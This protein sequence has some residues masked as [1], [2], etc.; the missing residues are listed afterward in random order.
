MSRRVE[1]FVAIGDSL[2]AGT[3]VEAGMAWPDRIAAGLR[4][5]YP[6]LT[7]SNLAVDG[8]KSAEVARQLDEALQLEPDLVT[9]ICGLNDLRSVSPDVAG[10]A[11]R[12]AGIIDCLQD[13]G[14]ERAIVT[15]TAPDVPESAPL[16]PRTRAHFVEGIRAINEATVRVASDRGVPCLGATGRPELHDPENLAA[17]GLHPS[18]RGHALM[19]REMADALRSYFDIEIDG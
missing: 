1:C 13:T 14:P 11:T 17:D 10:Y 18:P 4:G 15:A 5:S 7:F 19:A 3:G 8:A 6:D 16:R 12:L 2:T 9:V